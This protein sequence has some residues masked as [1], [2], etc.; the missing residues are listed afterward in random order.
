MPI[1]NKNQAK[2]NLE[3][4]ITQSSDAYLTPNGSNKIKSPN[5]KNWLKDMLDWI[6]PV[7]SVPITSLI[8]KSPV[9]TAEDYGSIVWRELVPVGTIVCWAGTSDVPDGY[10]LCDGTSYLKSQYTALSG[11]IGIIYGGTETSP[12]FNVPNLKGRVPIGYD[13]SSNT[14]PV[15]NPTYNQKNYKGMGNT[16]GVDNV[17]LSQSELPIHEHSAG[18]YK[19]YVPSGYGF[20]KKSVVGDG[21][22]TIGSNADSIGLGTEPNL[23]ATPNSSNMPVSGNS[24]QIG[25]NQPHENRMPYIVL[26]YIIKY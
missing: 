21:N 9:V 6:F 8:G 19:T 20:I 17:Q 4:N 18:S 1:N 13:V 23:V 11:V 5:L 2:Q 10:L 22:V 24:G 15:T 26:K 3:T 25:G 12:N 7:Q 14:E 16:G